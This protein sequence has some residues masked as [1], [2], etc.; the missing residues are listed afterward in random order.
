MVAAGWLDVGG[1]TVELTWQGKKFFLAGNE[2][3][4]FGVPPQSP[5]ADQPR[6][7]LAH[8]PDLFPWAQRE[9]YDL[10]F[11]GHTHGGQIRFPGVGPLI[12][13]SRFGFRYAS[14]VFHEGP[15]VMHVS[16][17]LS[18]EHLVRWNCRP[19]ITKLVLRSGRS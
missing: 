7:L 14:G 4:W 13:P 9:Q 5:A 15:T 3:P 1:Q 17:G 12:S 2:W 10:M 11:A 6:L 8:T 19:E 16:R 18:G